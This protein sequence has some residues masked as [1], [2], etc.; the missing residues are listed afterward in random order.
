MAFISHIPQDLAS[1]GGLYSR[2]IFDLLK[3]TW[4]AGAVDFI[5]PKAAVNPSRLASLGWGL[6]TSQPSKAVFAARS[7]TASALSRVSHG[8]YGFVCLNS[9]DA[10]PLV[11]R[12]LPDARLI[13]VCHNIESELFRQQVTRQPAL[14]RPLLENDVKRYADLEGRAFEKADLIIAI[15][16]VDADTIRSRRPFANVIHIPPVMEH[17]KRSGR[18]PAIGAKLRMGFV[19]RMQWWPNREAVDWLRQTLSP[20]PDGR[21]IHLF[22]DGSEEM[23]DAQSGVIGHGFVQDP[24]DLWRQIDVALCPMRSGGGVN[25]KLVE[26]LTRGVPVLTTSF[27]ARGLG[28]E[29]SDRPGLRILDDQDN[30]RSFVESDQITELANETPAPSIAS[31]FSASTHAPRLSSAL[32]EAV[33]L[34]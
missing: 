18:R 15:S 23:A 31:H 24:E 16:T 7:G 26:A 13:L 3:S 20:L 25:I 34:S 2:A 1:G 27:G 8:R 19:G 33:L 6:L 22:G 21:E 29:L 5:G 28:I 10:L 17:Q 4:T 11:E 30:W 32:K 14:A 12:Q 9:P